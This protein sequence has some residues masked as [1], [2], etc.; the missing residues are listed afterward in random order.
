MRRAAALAACLLLW[1]IPGRADDLE[2]R[3]WTPLPVGTTTVGLAAIHTTGEIAFD[4]LLQVQDAT[5]EADT[6]ALSLVRTFGFLGRL[7]RADL[8]LPH[9]HVTW[10][11]TLAGVPRSVDRRGL[12]DPVARLSVNL[13]GPPALDGAALRRYQ[14]EHPSYTV[15]G[16]ALALTLPLGEYLPDKL[17]N[18][19]QNRLVLRPQLGV[20]HRHGPWSFELTGSAFLFGD[21]GDFYAGQTRAQDP[22]FA[23]QAHLVYSSPKGW[24]VAMGGAID[25]GGESQVDGIPKDDARRDHVLGASAGVALSRNLG[26]R[27]TYVATRNEADIGSDTDSLGLSLS[28]RF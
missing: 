10:K 7:A 14:V 24:W 28:M 12:A 23:L 9:Q 3:R 21:N 4:P 15:L 16:A 20:L 22:L 17:L 27:L 13:L 1:V 6:W 25:R 26:A 2:P 8:V 19:G 18:I 5:V 11:G